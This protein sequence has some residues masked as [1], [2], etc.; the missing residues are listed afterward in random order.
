MRDLLANT[1]APTPNRASLP[2]LRVFAPGPSYSQHVTNRNRRKSFQNNKI[3]IS[4]RNSFP[5]LQSL[6]LT[7]WPLASL[8]PCLEIDG[9]TVPSRNTATPSTSTKVP[10]LIATEFAHRP[11]LLTCHSLAT[12]RREPPTVAT[13][14]AIASPSHL[15]NS[16]PGGRKFG[17]LTWPA[18][19][20]GSGGSGRVPGADFPGL[21]LSFSRQP[22][23]YAGGA[24]HLPK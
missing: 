7:L 3:Q 12:S 11:L 21:S 18:A 15:L 10:E 19:G 8:A 9:Y 16:G 1:P 14:L 2:A 5:H 24:L 6:A 20:Y 4:T 13:S 17:E 23:S 22:D